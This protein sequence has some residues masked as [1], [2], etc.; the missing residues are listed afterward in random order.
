MRTALAAATFAVALTAA[1]AEAG[2]IIDTQVQGVLYVKPGCGTGPGTGPCMPTVVTP[3]AF[4]LHITVPDQE[5]AKGAFGFGRL[6]SAGGY[7]GLSFGSIV[8]YL[9]GYIS[10]TP[11]QI[12]SGSNLTLTLMEH[13]LGADPLAF[14]GTV[15]SFT[16]V[17]TAQDFPYTDATITAVPEPNSWALMIAGFFGI[18]FATRRRQRAWLAL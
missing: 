5:V 7:P 17:R 4:D 6:G 15:A 16:G 10:N 18:G 1:P 11:T 8:V 2:V 3:I 9:S 13:G 12:V 14:S